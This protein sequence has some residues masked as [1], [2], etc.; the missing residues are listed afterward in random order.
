[1]HKN[2]GPTKNLDNF[3][4]FF[5]AADDEPG[6]SLDRFRR[7]AFPPRLGLPPRSRVFC[8]LLRTAIVALILLMSVPI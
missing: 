7:V 6:W 8:T 1:M 3:R 4:I 2:N 5:A